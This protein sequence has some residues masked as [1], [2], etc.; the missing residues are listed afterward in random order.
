M[1]WTSTTTEL[2]NIKE[3][4]KYTML[5]K[6]FLDVCTGSEVKRKDTAIN[7]GI[8]AVRKDVCK[9]DAPT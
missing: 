4:N 7:V 3:R 5:D 6:F 8:A 1:E 9:F 2:R